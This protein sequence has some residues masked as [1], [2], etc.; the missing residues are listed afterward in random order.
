MDP[1]VATNLLCFWDPYQYTPGIRETGGDA[2]GAH[3]P[4]SQSFEKL[5]YLFWDSFGLLYH[6][7]FS[8]YWIIPLA[9]K[10]ATVSPNSEKVLPWPY[11][12]PSLCWI[13]LIPFTEKFKSWLYSP[14]LLPLLPFSFQIR[15]LFPQRPLKN[16]SHP[17]VKSS[18]QLIFSPRASWS[19]GL[20]LITASFC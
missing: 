12:T 4:E 11:I 7:C 5:D 18:V 13:S 8:V 19:W 10:H 14:S 20:W 9:N 2:G 1:I 6:Y 17:V 3:V 16:I 15:L